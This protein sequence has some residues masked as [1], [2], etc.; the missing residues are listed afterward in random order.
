[1]LVWYRLPEV[2][3]GFWG[4]V[5][6]GYGGGTA[7]V[8]DKGSGA[9]TKQLLEAHD[10]GKKR[11]VAKTGSRQPTIGSGSS[12]SQPTIGSGSSS[13]QPTKGNINIS[14]SGLP[15][16]SGFAIGL[17]GLTIIKNLECTGSGGVKGI[18]MLARSKMK[19]NDKNPSDENGKGSSKGGEWSMF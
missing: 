2:S 15:P 8:G 14:G 1:M 19:K 11:S 17:R 12:S 10:S 6:L 7:R 16:P 5:G 4:A 18:G 9:Q 3:F 13:S